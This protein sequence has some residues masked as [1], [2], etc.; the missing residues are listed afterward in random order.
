MQLEPIRFSWVP[1]L[2]VAGGAAAAFAWL[3]WL[4]NR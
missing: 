1:L 3:G 2:F 4:L